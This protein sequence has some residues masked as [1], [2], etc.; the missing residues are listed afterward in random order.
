MGRVQDKV[1]IVTGGGTGIGRAI[2]VAFAREGARVMVCGRRLPPL[3]ETVRIIANAGGQ[4]RAGRCDVTDP[5]QIDA[6]VQQTL[7]SDGRIDV[8]CNN[9]GVRASI[10]TILDISVEEWDRTLEIDLKGAFLCCRRV[11][12]EMR[13]QSGGSIIMI[14]SISAHVGQPRQ[15]AYNAAKAGQDMLAKCLALD[16]AADGIRVNCVCPAWVRTEMNREQLAAMQ[17]APDKTFPPGLTYRELLRMHPLGRLGLPQ[18]VAAAAVYLASDE[19]GWVT[20]TCLMV[21]GG[22]TSQ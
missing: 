7:E 22:Y 21:D 3:E 19:S 14:S 10:G 8:L 1:A 12:P 11:I 20:G 4:A 18:D 15:G 6:L 17:E 5:D 9:A 2:A 13:S 16:F